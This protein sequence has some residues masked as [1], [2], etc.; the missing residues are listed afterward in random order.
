MVRDLFIGGFQWR[1]DPPIFSLT[2]IVNEEGA[3]VLSSLSF[4]LIRI[5]FTE[6]GTMVG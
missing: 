4:V 5:R 1:S 3:S 2:G 6:E